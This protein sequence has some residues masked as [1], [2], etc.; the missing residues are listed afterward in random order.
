MFGLVIALVLFASAQSSFAQV[1]ISLTANPPSDGEIQTNKTAQ[2]ASP[3]VAGGGLLV[4]GSLIATSN[5]TQT[6]LRITYPAP[7]T[8][9]PAI[10]YNSTSTTEFACPRAAGVGVPAADPI[11]IEGQT[12]VFATVTQPILNTASS[13]IE[14]WLPTIAGNSASGSF[15]IVGVRIDANGKTGAQSA[16]AALADAA[17]NYLLTTNSVQVINAIANGIASMSIGARSGQTNLGTGSV[18][19]NRTTPDKLASFTIVEGFASAFRTKIQSGNSGVALPNST[20]IRLTF[21]NVPSG[22]TLTLSLN[23]PAS[24]G[25]NALNADFV[26]SGTKIQTITSTA[27]TAQI[28]FTATSLTTTETLE[29]DV[30]DLTLTSTAAVTTEGAI[31][32]T[33]TFFPIGDAIDS[34]DGAP[35][36]ADGYPVFAQLD[37]GPTTIINI[38]SANTTLLI[39]LAEKVGVFDTGISVANTTSDPYGGLTGG[40]AVASSGTLTFNFFPS[41]ATG[42]GTSCTLTTSSTTRPGFGIASDGTVAAGATYV[43]LLSQLLPA[44]NCAAGDFV[45]YIFIT[46]RF[47]NAHG[48]ATISDF[49]TYSL[50][51]N[52]LVLAPPATS[53]RNAPG[54]GVESLGF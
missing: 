32:V 31:S 33:A 44:S 45:G 7:I 11:R 50:A 6:R 46:A 42:A 41:T 1:S 28:E 17:N 34:T 4:T 30:S 40:G 2:T 47:L 16:T 43:V 35:S 10:C 25:A 13:R 5:L 20:R 52:V 37:V 15:R 14:I 12:G 23:V 29:V 22:V 26:S 49:R 38:V 18:F 27:N 9:S 19:T 48:Q 36:A 53:P 24:T 54:T 8:S 51:A 21:N 3:G 39:P